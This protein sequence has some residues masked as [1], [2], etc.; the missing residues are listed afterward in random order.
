MS[1]NTKSKLPNFLKHSNHCKM[2]MAFKATIR[3]NYYYFPANIRSKVNFGQYMILVVAIC[4]RFFSL[5]SG[6][7]AR[8]IIVWLSIIKQNFL[9]AVLAWYIDISYVSYYVASN[10]IYCLCSEIRKWIYCSHYGNQGLR[11]L[12]FCMFCMLILNI[13]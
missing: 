7:P 10:L 13:I 12:Y 2:M 9:E 4:D 8:L 1:E 11:I 5:R 3:D 6:Y